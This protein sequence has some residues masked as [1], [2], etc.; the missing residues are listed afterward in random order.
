MKRKASTGGEADPPPES[1]RITRQQQRAVNPIMKEEEVDEINRIR[2]QDLKVWCSHCGKCVTFLTFV[3]AYST[4]YGG[5]NGDNWNMVDGTWK[6]TANNMPNE[7]VSGHDGLSIY[8]RLH[9]LKNLDAPATIPGEPSHL[10]QSKYIHGNHDA[11]LPGHSTYN[12]ESDSEELDSDDDLFEVDDDDIDVAGFDVGVEEEGKVDGVD[13]EEGHVADDGQPPPGQPGLPPVPEKTDPFY[14]LL[15]SWKSTSGTTDTDFSTLLNI[16]KTLESVPNVAPGVPTTTLYTIDS[17]LGLTK[18]MF[19]SICVCPTCGKLYDRV[20]CEVQAGNTAV[21]SRYCCDKALLKRSNTHSL[22]W[23]PVLTYPCVDVETALNTILR[24]P[25]VDLSLDHWKARQFPK[26]TYGDLY[27]GELWR[28]FQTWKGEEFLSGSGIA[29]MLNMDGFQPF[30]RRQYSVQ[31]IYLAIMNLPRHL[32]YRRENMIL[33]G[34]IPGGK[35]RIPLS[36]FIKRLADQLKKLWVSISKILK[37]R[38]A[39]LAIACD[40]PA[41]R[42]LCG[43]LSHSSPRGCSR[44]DCWY[45]TVPNPKGGPYKILWNTPMGDSNG[46]FLHRTRQEHMDYGKQWRKA[47]T[48]AERKAISK[49][50]GFRWTPLLLLEY[51]DP[52]RMLVL[53]PLHNIWEGLFKDLLK[54]FVKT[55]DTGTGVKKLSEKILDEFE[56]EVSNARFPR[57][58]G[59]VLG[60]IGHKMSRFTAHELKNMLNT[61]FGWLVDGSV[62]E[63]QYQLVQHLHVASRIADERVVTDASI[64]ELE[65]H[66]H[67]YCNLYAKVYGGGALKPNHHYSRHLSGFMRDYG[68]T[69]AFWLFAFERYNGIMTSFNTR[70]SV[71]ETS[72]FRQ[73]SIHSKLLQGLNAA[74]E[75]DLNCSENL[76]NRVM[77]PEELDIVNLLSGG[78]VKSLY[79]LGMSGPEFVAYRNISVRGWNT[80][81]YYEILGHEKFPGRPLKPREEFM[82]KC[83]ASLL[84]RSL[85]SLHKK[86]GHVWSTEDHFVIGDIK[87]YRELDMCGIIYQSGTSD[88]M[89]H[90]LFKYLDSFRPALVRYYCSVLVNMKPG[91]TQDEWKAMDFDRLL[92]ISREC[93]WYSGF[94]SRRFYFA[95]VDWFPTAPVGNTRRHFQ[96]WSVNLKLEP[97]YSFVPVARIISGFVPL[98][99]GSDSAFSCG[100]LRGHLMF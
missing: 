90:V 85:A 54:Q 13:A 19:D 9:D 57:S 17:S 5:R 41:G 40:V 34:L 48:P 30:K 27:E 11:L 88:R 72:M 89:S 53:D 52:S 77:S 12:D 45:E 80:D 82:T 33:V 65:D 78:V 46:V 59:P 16:L 87:K 95:R 50:T 94:K 8:T 10:L 4:H 55:T 74:Q 39:L 96:K 63:D 73:Y 7:P 100:P 66:L 22:L 31:G 92:A 60:K 84:R 44:C 79:K 56:R 76:T 61:F 6:V 32:R 18:D 81:T 51:F 75:K 68:P 97:N 49:N 47:D 14:L 36:Y 64:Q 3:S 91:Y 69:C 93:P 43:F 83:E 24:R 1:P 20:Q 2:A 15:R 38:V 99:G 26:G 70:A 35:E 28:D 23:T 71:V 62:S 98:L 42:K 37:R 25:G 29:V 58:M 21:R 67:A 86:P